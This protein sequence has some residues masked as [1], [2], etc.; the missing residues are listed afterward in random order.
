LFC[1]EQGFEQNK[2]INKLIFMTSSVSQFFLRQVSLRLSLVIIVSCAF[3]AG[4]LIVKK[5]QELVNQMTPSFSAQN[6]QYK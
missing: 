3:V 5:T 2:E 1:F 4:L 6:Q